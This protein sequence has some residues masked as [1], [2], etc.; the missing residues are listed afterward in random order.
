VGHFRLFFLGASNQLF[1]S[2]A[3]TGQPF[4][5][6]DVS[7]GGTVAAGVLVAMTADVGEGS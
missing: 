3:G 7:D 4:A 1:L 5:N 6:F 2:T